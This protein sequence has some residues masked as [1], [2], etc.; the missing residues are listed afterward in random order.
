MPSSG[1]EDVDDSTPRPRAD[2]TNG[3]SMGGSAS[4]NDEE[5]RPRNEEQNKRQRT[6]SL[7]G[8][9]MISL[10]EMSNTMNSAIASA[11]SSSGSAVSSAVANAEQRREH[12]ERQLRELQMKEERRTIENELAAKYGAGFDAMKAKVDGV[13]KTVGDLREEHETVRKK[14]EDD[15]A[16]MRRLKVVVYFIRSV[17]VC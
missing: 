10:V 17:C 3:A 5:Q 16:V 12:M 8:R 1:D 11:V 9:R 2:G 14:L 15:L 7:G 13:D 4:N 6:A